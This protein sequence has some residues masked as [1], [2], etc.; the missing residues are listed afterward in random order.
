MDAAH[1][2]PEALQ[3]DSAEQLLLLQPPC[4][5]VP[6]EHS[7]NY[8]DGNAPILLLFIFR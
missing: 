5:E 2:S 6:P 8:S 4:L 3:G 7:L 1:P